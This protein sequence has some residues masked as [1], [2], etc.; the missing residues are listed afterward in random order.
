MRQWLSVVSVAIASFAFVT[1]EFL[2]VGLLPQIAD[3]LGVTQGTA[4]LTVTMPGLVAALSAPGLM[5]LAGKMNRRHLFLAL[6]ALLLIANLM[7]AFAP[8]FGIMLIG[9][10]LFGA[11]IGGFWTLAT[12]SAARLVAPRDAA[13]AIATILTGVTLATVFGVPL[14]TFVADISSW[15]FSIVATTALAGVAFIAQW[16]LVPSLP[17]TA[18]L[19]SKDLFNLLRRPHARRGLLMMA[20]LFFA[21]FGTYTYITPFLLHEAGLGMGTITWMLF[22][23]GVVGFAANYVAAL[24]V[25]RRM[26]ATTAAMG[27]LMTLALLTLPLFR[28]SQVLVVID[29][30]IWGVAFGAL[31]L[32][33]SVWTQRATPDLPE[34]ASA[35]YI[36]SIEAA[37]GFGSMVGGLVVDHA[38]VQANFV[39][40]GV[41]ALAALIVLC[42]FRRDITS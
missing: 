1:T 33:S 22:G 2:P 13:K 21:H 35:L 4:G 41:V 23:F 11:G 39:M 8:S 27:L 40:G 20:L 5:I 34:A 36:F 15:R 6:T 38:G 28:P 9:R 29:V 3:A 18:A 14:G 26:T 31:P 24:M 30:M 12:A 37:I 7:S 25:D 42:T 32:S 17:S 16:A 19:K 10:A